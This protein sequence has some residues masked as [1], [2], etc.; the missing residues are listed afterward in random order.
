MW[1]MILLIFLLG[2]EYALSSLKED[3][4]QPR[5]SAPQL[6]PLLVHYQLRHSYLSKNQI[7]CQKVAFTFNSIKLMNSMLLKMCSFVNMKL[8]NF[9]F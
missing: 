8:K 3:L 2:V 7:C 6:L 9:R 1:Q 4:K 5:G